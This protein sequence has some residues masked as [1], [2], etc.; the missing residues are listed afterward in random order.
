[1]KIC[2]LRQPIQN[3]VDKFT[4]LSIRGF[5]LE[6]FTASFSQFSSTTD[7]IF[8]LGGRLGTYYQLQASEIFIKFPHFLR[9]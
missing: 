6:Y 8:L 5:S 3:I 7:K 2:F 9:S 1:M 4:K